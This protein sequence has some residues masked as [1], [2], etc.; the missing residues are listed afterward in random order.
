MWLLERDG[1][2]VVDETPSGTRISLIDG[3]SMP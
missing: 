2:L 3:D 1:R